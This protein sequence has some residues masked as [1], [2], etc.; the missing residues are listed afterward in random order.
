[1]SGDCA[2][3]SASIA[4]KTVAQIHRD[5]DRNG[6]G[7]GRATLNLGD[8]LT[9]YAKQKAPCLLREA[10]GVA[11]GSEGGGSHPPHP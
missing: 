2:R 8:M 10:E 1:M 9:P 11:G 3:V 6:S 4:R 7:Y 5:K